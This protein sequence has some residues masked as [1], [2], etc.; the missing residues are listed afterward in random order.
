MNSPLTN[1][2]LLLC[3]QMLNM[4]MDVNSHYGDWL[5]W[6]H[7]KHVT[8]SHGLFKNKIKKIQAMHLYTK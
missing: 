8:L 5:L 7:L 4:C 6:L 2:L 1:D 3:K